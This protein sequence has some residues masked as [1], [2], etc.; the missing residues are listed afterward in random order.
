MRE[1]KFRVWNGKEY[2][3]FGNL[4]YGVNS[5]DQDCLI[6]NEKSFFEV[7]NMGTKN[8]DYIIEQYTKLKDKN[9]VEIYEGD[10]IKAERNYN[11]NNYFKIGAVVFNEKNSCY[12]VDTHALNTKRLS[13]YNN[14]EVIGN[15]HEN[16]ELLK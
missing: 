12:E 3:Y 7:G 14:I 13:A 10:I 11:K 8:H 1:I 2:K 15:I 9:G 6:F 5:H 4:F 16:K